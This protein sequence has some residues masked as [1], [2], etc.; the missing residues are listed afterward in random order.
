M[1]FATRHFH[2]P[3]DN[4]V[5]QHISALC[6]YLHN[7]VVSNHVSNSPH[8]LPV[9]DRHTGTI[10][11]SLVGSAFSKHGHGTHEMAINLLNPVRHHRNGCLL[12]FQN[13]CHVLSTINKI[14]GYIWTYWRGFWQPEF[15][16]ENISIIWWHESI[17]IVTNIYDALQSWC[18]LCIIWHIQRTWFIFCG[19]AWTI[20]L[21]A[22]GGSYLKKTWNESLLRMQLWMFN[23]HQTMWPSFQGIQHASQ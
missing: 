14:Y 6:I 12:F 1:H 13:K 19:I 23:H 17:L 7:M 18:L 8:P 21:F 11:L 2:E 9:W 5:F 3:V 4:W 20:I 15:H 22:K 16:Q 10:D